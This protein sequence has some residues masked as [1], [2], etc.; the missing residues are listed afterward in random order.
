MFFKNINFD[1]VS[2]SLIQEIYSFQVDVQNP[3]F[4]STVKAPVVLIC[5]GKDIGK[6]TFARYLTNS[7]LN[8]YGLPN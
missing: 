4:S 3:S 1:G 2:F 8:R 6:S 5:G 7:L